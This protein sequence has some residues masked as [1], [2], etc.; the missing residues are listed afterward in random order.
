MGTDAAL[1][2]DTIEGGRRPSLTTASSAATAWGH[3]NAGK[4]AGSTLRMEVST[5]T[6]VTTTCLGLSQAIVTAP[7][8][9]RVRAMSSGG[10]CWTMLA[11]RRMP[12]PTDKV[13][14]AKILTNL[15][16]NVTFD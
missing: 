15:F 1:N 8:G 14:F 7:N 2:A 5:R 3:R 13:L 4:R 12:D 16:E 9:G 11:K 6:L 10:S